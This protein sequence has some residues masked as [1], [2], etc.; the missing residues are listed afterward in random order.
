M[1]Q[2]GRLKSYLKDGSAEYLGLS[3][4]NVSDLLDEIAINSRSRYVSPSTAAFFEGAQAR[5]DLG[6]SSVYLSQLTS[7]GETP[8]GPYYGE[9]RNHWQQGW[10]WKDGRIRMGFEPA[11][12]RAHAVNP[13][14]GETAE[15]SFVSKESSGV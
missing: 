12:D 2:I 5:E 3:R 7:V 10:Q 15:K 4:A 13:E 1:S 11:A 8:I 14:P 6:E 9:L